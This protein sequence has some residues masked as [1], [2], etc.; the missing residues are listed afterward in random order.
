MP[1]LPARSV[2]VAG[3]PCSGKTTYVELHKGEDDLVLDF[4]SIA[5]DLGSP[6][7]WL[8]PQPYRGH[9]EKIMRARIADLPGTGPG[10]AWVIRSAAQPQVRAIASR[11]M[12]AAAC[13]LIDPGINVCLARAK[14]DGRPTGT[15]D[16]I[17]HWYATF[18]RWSGDRLLTAFVLPEAA[19]PVPA[20]LGF[21]TVLDGPPALDGTTPLLDPPPTP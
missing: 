4:D 17:L 16:Q 2:L 13:I 19:A 18:K 1:T 9:A 15:A 8:H 3:P 10:T 6:V 12:R 21:F 14:A 7:Q 20:A 5:R 11:Q